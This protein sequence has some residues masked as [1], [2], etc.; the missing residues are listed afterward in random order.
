[1]GEAGR[2]TDAL[3]VAEEAVRLCQDLAV[4]DPETCLP[5]VAATVHR[6]AMRRNL[7]GHGDDGVVEA[8]QLVA[9]FA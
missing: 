3:T 4:T 6:L 8:E 2:R 9:D 1:L 5:G 7:E